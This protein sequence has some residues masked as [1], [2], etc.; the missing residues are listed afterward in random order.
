MQRHRTLSL[1]GSTRRGPASLLYWLLTYGVPVAVV[2]AIV[3]NI[4]LFLKFFFQHHQDTGFEASQ[5]AAA[6][7]LFLSYPAAIT[8][9]PDR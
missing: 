6:D 8:A 5:S 9:P 7:G 1:R 3:A 4:Y 2:G